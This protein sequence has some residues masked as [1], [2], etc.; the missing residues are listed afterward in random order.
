MVI[1]NELGRNCLLAFQ[2][3]TPEV[4]PLIIMLLEKKD[5]QLAQLVGTLKKE[6]DDSKLK[7]Y[8]MSKSDYRLSKKDAFIYLQEV[9]YDLLSKEEAKV[10]IEIDEKN[11][12]VIK[13]IGL[14][15]K[16]V[17]DFLKVDIDMKFLKTFATN[18][19]VLRLN[20]FNKSK[21]IKIDD[22]IKLSDEVKVYYVEVSQILSI[23][24][25]DLITMYSNNEIPNNKLVKELKDVVLELNNLEK[26]F[27][28]LFII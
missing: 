16:Q 6:E 13:Y 9:L 2:N 14:S 3:M 5:K 8:L 26:S 22:T 28:D 7:E 10:K 18:N 20:T 19:I 17:S 25:E 12:K 21:N 24:T 27:N 4:K 15:K 11:I 23:S 1:L